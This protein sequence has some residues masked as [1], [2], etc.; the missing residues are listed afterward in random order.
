V[1]QQLVL[2]NPVFLIPPLKSIIPSYH[3]ISVSTV[4]HWAYLTYLHVKRSRCIRARAECGLMHCI[5]TPIREQP[6]RCLPTLP[7]TK[8]VWWAFV[9]VSMSC[10]IAYSCKYRRFERDRPCIAHEV[11]SPTTYT[12][13]SRRH[14]PQHQRMLADVERCWA[15]NN[16]KRWWVN[17]V[18]PMSRA[19][20]S[21]ALG[22]TSNLCE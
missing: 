10:K 20:D 12:H 5:A 9:T 6:G 15:C 13:N 1:P 2:D 16:T 4:G 7:T 19:P 22:G 17:H 18:S 3:W 11:P 14:A 21:E 8:Y